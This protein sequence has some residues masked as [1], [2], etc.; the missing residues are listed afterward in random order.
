M[1]H[2]NHPLPETALLER[3]G[4]RL[5]SADAADATGPPDVVAT[6]VAVE[7][8]AYRRPG[9]KA[10]FEAGGD[11]IGAI[12][13]GCLEDDLRRATARVRAT[14]AP[15]IETYD[16]TAEDGVWGLGLGC[17]GVV[18]VLLEPLEA[19]Y[20]RAVEPVRTRRDV[21]VC[22]VLA[23]EGPLERGDRAYYLP[24]EGLFET[25]GTDVT[26]TGWPTAAVSGPAGEM[27]SEGR[28][29]V[30]ELSVGGR[31]LDVFVEAIP[32]PP[33]CLV[34]GSGPDVAP[35]VDLAS[36]ADF[37]VV[38]VGFRGAVD[39]EGRFP[40]A[41]RTVTTSPR[42]LQDAVAI[43]ERT[44]AVVMTHNFVDD[45]L[46]LETLLDSP[47][48]YVGIMGP[49][50][51]FEELRA[52]LAAD[53]R[54]VSEG[55]LERIY[56]PIGLDLGLG[57]PAGIAQSVVAELLAVSRDRRPGHLR[58]RGGPIHDRPRPDDLSG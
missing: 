48:P 34:F 55:D 41:D 47:A 24:D 11:G 57:T 2:D 42:D 9:A 31:R 45:R 6:V 23:A 36:R 21:A 8:A 19:H 15:R 58:D 52:E 38:V 5:D 50:K 54:P 39:L 1:S 51:R 12:T 33:T 37:R 7:G 3:I 22:T 25:P 20:R 17:N 29:G 16:L 44:H 13:A 46:V 26:A 43:D 18:T 53:G 27:T 28:S 35:V 10:L 32:A 30:V 14:G 40:G 49:R 4:D 56:A